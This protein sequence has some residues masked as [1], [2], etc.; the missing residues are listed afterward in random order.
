MLRTYKHL[1]S[2]WSYPDYTEEQLL[3]AVNEYKRSFP[4]RKTGEKYGF[5]FRARKDRADGTHKKK[6]KNNFD[7]LT[8]SMANVPPDC[9]INYNET[10]LSD[11]PGRA[12]LVFKRGTKYPERILNNT[13]SCTSM[14]AG[15]PTGIIM[16]PYIAFKAEHI[17]DT[18]CNGGPD[19]TRYNHSK[20][21][22]F[23]SICLNDWFMTVIVPYCRRVQDL[24][25]LI[26]DNLS[27][28][29]N[30][31]IIATCETENIR[32]VFLPRS[33]TYLTQ[34]LNMFFWPLKTKWKQI[35]TD[36]IMQNT[37][38]TTLLK[39]S[40]APLLKQLYNIIGLENNQNIASGFKET[41]IYPL[42]RHCVLH[43]LPDAVESLQ[44][45]C[46]TRKRTHK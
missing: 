24:K 20:S 41:G 32:F 30:A 26:G 8:A 28:H 3:A 16:V 22:W 36:W 7:N 2:C 9:I 18:W 35:L 12:K 44:T 43:K 34:P 13:K 5:P 27:P 42:N 19:G 4:L 15:T 14:F 23:D 38:Q 10:N 29:L 6:Q 21:S 39:G 17:W 40:F 46:S 1:T 31:E 33:S 37:H 11:D 25:L 45:F